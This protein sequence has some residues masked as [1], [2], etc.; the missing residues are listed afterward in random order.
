MKPRFRRRALYRALDTKRKRLGHSWRQ[1][2]REMGVHDMTFHRV[3]KHGPPLEVYAKMV[4][5][6]RV[7]PN[8]FFF[9]QKRR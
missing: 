3:P 6:L 5:W 8:T 4:A 7:S 9:P 2:G 1:V